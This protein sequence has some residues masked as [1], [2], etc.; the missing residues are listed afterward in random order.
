[1]I[2]YDIRGSTAP[3]E[4]MRLGFSVWARNK[5][6]DYLLKYPEAAREIASKAGAGRVLLY[7]LVDDI[8]PKLSLSRT[9]EEQREIS[10]C[11]SAQLPGLGFDEVHLVSSF[12][13]EMS[14]GGYWHHAS[15]V[16]V[17]EFWKVLPQSKRGEADKLDLTEALS[18][19]W[20][21]HVLGA[22]FREFHLSALLAGIRS[23]FFYL[24]ARKLLPPHDTYFIK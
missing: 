2:A 7:A 15:K 16:S 21:I 14:L 23:E 8:W 3:P 18:F 19:I 11:Y 12:V 4:V 9:H 1:M 20:H 13:E 24:A 10:L 22:A 6:K 17:P 5:P